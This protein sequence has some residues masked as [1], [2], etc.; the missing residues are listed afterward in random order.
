MDLARC[1]VDAVVLEGRSLPRG[2]QRF[3]HLHKG[4]TRPS[5]ELQGMKTN[6]RHRAHPLASSPDDEE[7]ASEPIRPSVGTLVD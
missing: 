3:V 7:A 4:K 5:L 1:V 2:G 6:T